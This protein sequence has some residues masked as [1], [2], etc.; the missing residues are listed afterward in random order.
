MH[1]TRFFASYM[2]YV[3]LIS[4]R[5]IWAT[6]PRRSIA[7]LGLRC[8]RKHRCRAANIVWD[9]GTK[10]NKIC[11]SI[12]AGKIFLSKLGIYGM[13]SESFH[14]QNLIKNMS[15]FCTTYFTALRCAA[16]NPTGH[17]YS[18]CMEQSERGE[19]R[20]GRNNSTL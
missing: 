8:A 13:K 7:G 18:Y 9:S 2:Q 19:V 6:T 15:L 17:S 4:G 12:S 5:I 16:A 14:R 20:A 10:S 11:T 3:I 1:T